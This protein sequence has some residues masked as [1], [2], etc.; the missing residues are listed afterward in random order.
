MKFLLNAF[1]LSLFGITLAH[2]NIA[3][4]Q[5]N[6]KKNFPDIP[7]QSVQTT[8]LKDIYE[9]Y[10]GRQIVYTNDDANYFFVGN[11]I[12][13]KNHKNLTE[14]SLQK[15]EKID[16]STNRLYWLSGTM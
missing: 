7:V 8:P 4:V 15:L 16:V 12:D 10:M 5:E 6:L 11:L 13:N 9:V 1:T 14:E 2:A 3:T